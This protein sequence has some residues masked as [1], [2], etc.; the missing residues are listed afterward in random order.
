MSEQARLETAIAALEARRAL[1]GDAVV[2]A[3]LVSMRDRLA[4]LRNLVLHVE[5]VGEAID[6][7]ERGTS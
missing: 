4:G 1:L 5:M 7:K 6:R 3:A 2:E